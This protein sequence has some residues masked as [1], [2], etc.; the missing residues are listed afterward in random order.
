MIMYAMIMALSMLYSMLC[1]IS[2]ICR[3]IAM[4]E[5]VSKSAAYKSEL[6]LSWISEVRK[7]NRVI[8]Y[9]YFLCCRHVV[10]RPYSDLFVEIDAENV[11]NYSIFRS[12]YTRD[13]NVTRFSVQLKVISTQ[14]SDMQLLKVRMSFMNREL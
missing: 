2:Y 9:R 6:M 13:I 12:I 5:H 7:C 10:L 11:K 1:V 3:Q 4:T 8:R 14:L